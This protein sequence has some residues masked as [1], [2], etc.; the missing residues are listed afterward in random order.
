[1]P[2]EPSLLGGATPS[3][4]KPG[5]EGLPAEEKAPDLTPEQTADLKA[6]LYTLFT[7]TRQNAPLPLGFESQF[8]AV[9]KKYPRDP[10]VQKMREMIHETNRL[11]GAP[12]QPTEQD[13]PRR[14]PVR[15]GKRKRR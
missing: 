15:T 3:E 5:P 12:T 7:K 11:F 9:E 2:K 8:E 13:R 1:M 4:S 14:G 6:T 10:G